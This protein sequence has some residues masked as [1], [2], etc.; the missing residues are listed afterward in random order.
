MAQT[1]FTG[2]L[3]GSSTPFLASGDIVAFVDVSDTTQSA[4][5]SLVKGTLTQ[6][7]AQL[8]VPVAILST[9][10]TAFTVGRLGATTPA[11]TVDA[12]TASQ[13]AGLK[14]T[15]AATA[16]TV[17]VVV[18]D[19][20]SDANL[21]VNAKGSGTIGIGSVSTGRV[22]ITPVCTI[23]GALTQTGLATF[24]GGATIASGQTLT[25]TG[26]TVA[27]Q[28]TW[29]STQ[30]MN[31]SG[32]AAGTAGSVAA[33]SITGTTLAANVVT[34]SITTIGTLV[35]GA[36][37]ASLVTAG[38]FPAGAFVFAGALSGITTLVA[39]ST[40]QGTT[41]TGTTGL[42]AGAGSGL[43]TVQVNAGTGTAGYTSYRVNSSDKWFTGTGIVVAGRYEI[44]DAV[45]GVAALSVVPGAAPSVVF[46]GA[47]SG[48]TTLALA[49]TLGVGAATPAASGSGVS[50]PASQSAS[51]DANTLD[52]Y[53]EGSWT[54]SIG[55]TATYTAQTGRYIKIGKMVWFS[56]QLQINSLGTGSTGTVSGLPFT[57]AAV[58]GQMFDIGYFASSAEN[59]TRMSGSIAS[60]G[61]TFTIIGQLA[62]DDTMNSISPIQSGF[63]MYFSG[64][65]EAA[66]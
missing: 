59:T 36:V 45:N 43:A 53:E 47:A 31:I 40:I 30:S 60:G 15:G 27:G 48:I 18:T 29:S 52:D 54:P 62:I 10:A 57:S 1:P 6:F 5:G 37:P 4:S 55:G 56:G 11:F 65:Y 35:A 2:L 25:L 63:I 19:S 28:P 20:G 51:A 58:T 39:S 61:T 7:F 26:A 23:T 24:N 41:L 16:G 38:T 12:S 46:A 17:A 13:V 50:F 32:N 3:T 44:Y 66:A 49:T 34:T 9:S 33:A 22:T 8:P 64:C 14:I 21:T 42:I